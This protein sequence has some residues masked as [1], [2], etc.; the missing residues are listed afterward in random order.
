MH[1]IRFHI[2]RRNRANPFIIICIVFA[3]I[4]I[5]PHFAFSWRDHRA[6]NCN[7]RKTNWADT[8]KIGAWCMER[9]QDETSTPEESEP[10]LANDDIMETQSTSS[11]H[12][13]TN[14]HKYG[15]FRL[16]YL[17]MQ[18]IGGAM[19]ILMLGWVF[20]HLGGLSWSSTPAV[21]FNWHPLLMTVGMIY[22]YGNC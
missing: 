11:T 22:L 3:Y 5:V 17:L 20:I 19:I 1:S 6:V 10:L 14:H 4:C 16:L 9:D 8:D 12:S 21:Q 15:D 13:A 18:M 7:S 2:Y